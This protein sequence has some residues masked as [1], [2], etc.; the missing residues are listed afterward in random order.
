MIF[1]IIK[2]LQ[3][4]YNVFNVNTLRLPSLQLTYTKAN[5]H[6]HEKHVNMSNIVTLFYYCHLVAH[7]LE[8]RRPRIDKKHQNALFNHSFHNVNLYLD[9][10]CMAT[11]AHFILSYIFKIFVVRVLSCPYRGSSC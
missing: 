1:L 9:K 10:Q 4:Y 6:H 2:S 3:H 7:T 5:L 11:K 8:E